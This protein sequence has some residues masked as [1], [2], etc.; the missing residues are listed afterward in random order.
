[1]APELACMAIQLG[2]IRLIFGLSFACMGFF[3][4]EPKSTEP[5][6]AE[7]RVELSALLEWNYLLGFA[8]AQVQSCYRTNWRPDELEPNQNLYMNSINT[9]SDHI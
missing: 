1:M 4:G 3:W 6:N 8:S 5:A 7:N 9:S 2:L